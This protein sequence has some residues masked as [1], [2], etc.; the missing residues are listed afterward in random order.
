MQVFEI[1]IKFSRTKKEKFHK[2]DN[3]ETILIKISGYN[4]IFE[5]ELNYLKVESLQ[6]HKY[7]H[8]SASTP[9]FKFLSNIYLIVLN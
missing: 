1:L 6:F 2:I 5:L 8:F 7:T 9:N 4:A 3:V